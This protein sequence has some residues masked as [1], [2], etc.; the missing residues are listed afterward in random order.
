MKSL[1]ARLDPAHFFAVS[2]SAIVNLNRV[3]EI[4]SF[5]R[6]SHIVILSDGTQVT[7]SRA[8]REVLERRLGQSL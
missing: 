3:R 5:A 2:R 4:Q 1:A 6:G 7:L 8:R